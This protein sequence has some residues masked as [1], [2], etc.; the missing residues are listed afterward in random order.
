MK[1]WES[2]FWNTEHL[3]FQSFIQSTL[4]SY[5]FKYLSPPPTHRFYKLFSFLGYQRRNTARVEISIQPGVRIVETPVMGERTKK[6]VQAKCILHPD[7]YFSESG[8]IELDFQHAC[9]YSL[10]H[11]SSHFTKYSRKLRIS[12][13]L[14]Y[15]KSATQWEMIPLSSKQIATKQQ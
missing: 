6:L 9:K 4:Q 14:S 2:E 10:N 5:I 1:I 3:Y 13:V 15:F 7:V 11:S 8:S 12:V